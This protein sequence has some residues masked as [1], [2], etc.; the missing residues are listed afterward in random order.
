M[1]TA[2]CNG[3]EQ[4]STKEKKIR[5]IQHTTNQAFMF[6]KAHYHVVSRFSGFGM[7]GAWMS[8]RPVQNRIFRV[9]SDSNP[10]CRAGKFRDVDTDPR[11]LASDWSGI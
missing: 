8:R 3:N 5:L 7:M 6:S 9:V 10:V 1:N 2:H 11:E 4:C